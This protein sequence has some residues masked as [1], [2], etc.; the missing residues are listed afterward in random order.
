MKYYEQLIDERVFGYPELTKII[1]KNQNTIYS[2]IREYLQK[3]YV[4]QVKKGLY[5]A[6]SME[7]GAPV[8][9][10]FEIG[11]HIL[12]NGYISHHSA[13]EYLG[14][15]NQIMYTVQVSGSGRFRPFSFDGYQYQCFQERIKQGVFQKENGIKVTDTERTVLD[16]VND[17]E[18]TGGISELYHCL[19][20]V[21]FLDEDRLLYYLELYGK[22]F[23]YQKAGFILEALKEDLKLTDQF[24]DKCRERMGKSKRYFSDTMERRTMEYVSA[25][26]MYV[27]KD[28]KRMVELEE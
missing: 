2:L 13:F 16:C 10:R 5:V 19:Q 26:Q 6:V 1:S 22:Q 11:S 23:L 24:F 18:K 21:P 20:M 7:T 27:P 15:T 4:E 3:H 28:F 8:A 14:F 9:S 25:W 17:L 12:E